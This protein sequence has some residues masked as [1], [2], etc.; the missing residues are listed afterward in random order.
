[1]DKKIIE[2]IKKKREFSELPD[3]I[4]ERFAEISG[5]GVKESRA[6]LRKYFGVFLTNRVLKS[7][8]DFDEILKAHISSKKRNYEEFYKSFT[9]ERGFE[10]VVDFGSGVN[11][12]S[13][14]Y[15][16]E[17]F[18]DVNYYAVEAS[19]QLVTNMNKFFDDNHF[20]GRAIRGDLMDFE[21]VG[22]VL[23]KAKGK[24]IVFLFQVVDALETLEK[25]SSKRLLEYLKGHL[26]KE[27]L[28]VLTVPTESIGGRKKFFV[29]R[30]WLLDFLSESFSV[31]K[32]F[33]EFGERI[34]C[35]RK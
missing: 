1:M 35:F 21:F 34:I 32:D 11:G 30:K 26:S 20:S 4:V 15:L 27:D 12:Y 9:D 7:K 23:S 31:E 16:R 3:S 19:G 13:Y 14:P 18:G 33:E 6:L 24:K 10:S 2:E 8:G 25:N 17:I 5:G 28:V 22:S 29:Q